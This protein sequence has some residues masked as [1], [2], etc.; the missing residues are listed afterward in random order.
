MR[1][2]VGR[3][4]CEANSQV[5]RQ[6]GTFNNLFNETLGQIRVNKF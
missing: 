2:A 4:T 1:Y 3:W 6:H 5:E